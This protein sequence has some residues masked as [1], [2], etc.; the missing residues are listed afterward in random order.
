MPDDLWL[1]LHVI[2]TTY[3]CFC[4]WLLVTKILYPR[5][6]K[7]VSLELITIIPRLQIKLLNKEK[8]ISNYT[9]ITYIHKLYFLS[10]FRVACNTI[11]MWTIIAFNFSRASILDFITSLHCPIV[12]NKRTSAFQQQRQHSDVMKSKMASGGKFKSRS[13]FRL[14]LLLL[15][16]NVTFPLSDKICNL[17]IIYS[18]LAS[19]RANSR[20]HIEVN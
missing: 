20:S 14:F 12:S 11:N 6:S 3:H 7:Q 2:K 8:A 19:T 1:L 17:G 13:L 18:N 10:N 15:L 4:D 5:L 9:Y 16:L